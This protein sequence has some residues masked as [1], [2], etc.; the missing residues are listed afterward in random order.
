MCVRVNQSWQ[1]RRAGKI[2]HFCSAGYSNRSV[3]NFF[4]SFTPNKNE[5]ILANASTVAIDQRAG[6]NHSQR[7]GS[8]RSRARLTHC[9]DHHY[10]DQA[11]THHTLAHFILQNRAVACGNSAPDANDLGIF[12]R[13]AEK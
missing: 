12:F 3:R 10:Q 4:D 8:S 1:N 13:L 11:Y 7:R 6:P 2:N 9:T 5:L